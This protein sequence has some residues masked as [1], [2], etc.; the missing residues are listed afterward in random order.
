M[1]KMMKT[2]ITILLVFVYLAGW[3]QES[4]SQPL[5]Q[6][7]NPIQEYKF[8]SFDT[9]QFSLNLKDPLEL[10]FNQDSTYF[11]GIYN[12]KFVTPAPPDNMPVL[13]FRSVPPVWNMPVYEPDSSV[14]YYIQNP[15][16]QSQSFPPKKK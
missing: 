12:Q 16:L 8:Q 11:S 15:M 14:Q 6:E 10:K 3:S 13:G 7:L 4:K 1:I 2:I 5:I 9:T